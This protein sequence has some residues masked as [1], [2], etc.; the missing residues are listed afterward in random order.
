MGQEVIVR[1]SKF[2]VHAWQYWLTPK[3]PLPQ[4][5]TMPSLVK[6]TI[7]AK[8]KRTPGDIL[9]QSNHPSLPLTRERSASSPG[10]VL[11]RFDTLKKNERFLPRTLLI[12]FN[13][14]ASPI[15]ST[16]FSDNRIS[17]NG[18]FGIRIFANYAGN[19]SGTEHLL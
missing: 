12:N 19:L 5:I 7:R 6:E 17:G 14:G 9:H 8:E 2:I 11:P 4:Y 13:D 10:E 16:G 1:G 18:D 3:C 15:D